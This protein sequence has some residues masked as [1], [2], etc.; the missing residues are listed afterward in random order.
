MTANSFL[1]TSHG[2]IAVTDNG[3]RGHPVL[4]LHGNSSCKEV[5]RKQFDS[6]VGKEFRLIAFDLPGHGE[7]EDAADPARTYNMPAYAELAI[8]VLTQLGAR[9]AAMLG[10]SLGGHIGLEMIPRFPGLKGL[11]IVGTPPVGQTMEEV[12]EG[13]LPSPEM[14]LSGQE[15]FSDKDSEAYAR[16][17]LGLD[18]PVDPHMLGCVR[19]TDGRARRYMFEAFAAGK[20]ESHK[21]IAATAKIPLAVL[22]GGSEPLINIAY[23]PKARYANL[24]DGALYVIPGVGHAAFWEAPDAFNPLFLRF[25]RSIWS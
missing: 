2:R 17:T 5:F 20:G 13:F 9:A 24:W 21:K 10:W 3:G 16:Y 1:K 6:P 14:Q 7:S 12:G 22:N 25:L 23:F 4:L 18:K 15:K 11:M 8:E 19:R